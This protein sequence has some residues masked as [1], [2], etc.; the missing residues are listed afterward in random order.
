[1]DAESVD[2]SAI[3]KQLSERAVPT[4]LARQ[5]RTRARSRS[6]AWKAALYPRLI[7]SKAFRHVVI[8]SYQK[9]NA[10]V[11]ERMGQRRIV[12]YH[13]IGHALVA[14]ARAIPG[15]QVDNIT[16]IPRTLGC[17][18][19]YQTMQVEDG[20][21]LDASKVMSNTAATL[22]GVVVPVKN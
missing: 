13:D 9:K 8:A 11:S 7:W 16:I 22:T 15:S 14:R 20:E 19:L 2:F 18:R 12:A 5:Y 17:S 4:S 3:A 1:M 21:R 10:S 6:S